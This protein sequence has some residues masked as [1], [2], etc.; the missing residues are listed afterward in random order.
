MPNFT[1]ETTYRLPIYR[2]RTYD[3]ETLDQACDLAIAD[4]GWDDNKS[5]VESSGD[6]Y[7]TGVWEGQD[8]AYIGRPLTFPSRFDEQVQRKAD[9]FEVLLG[10]LK[11]L[12]H[13]PEGGSA[14]VELWRR[15]ADAAIAKAEAI[16]AAENDPIEG[17]AS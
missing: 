3:A 15:R 1:I 14:D 5:N 11:I 8:A 16:L 6:T 7:V 2:Q 12:A 17:A 10:L 9:H 4:E 13:A